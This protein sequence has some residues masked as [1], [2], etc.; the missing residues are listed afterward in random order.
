MHF[1]KRYKALWYGI[2]ALFSLVIVRIGYTHTFRFAFLFWNFFLALLPLYFSF[3][4]RNCGGTKSKWLFAGL[5]LMFFPNSAY[6]LT[7]IVHLSHG[8]HVLYWLDVMILFSAGMYGLV[9]SMQSLKEME[10]WYGQFV[11]RRMKHCITAIL[12]LTCGYGIYLG[13]IER[14]NSWDVVAQPYDLLQAIFHHARH[15]FQRREVWYMTLVFA[16]GLQIIYS[17]FG[18][19]NSILKG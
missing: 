4:F 9:I 14:W 2:S 17:L 3:R 15:P 8:G 7:D 5:W 12:L 1:L 11:S 18:R 13:R 16:V 10:N 6:L 19:R